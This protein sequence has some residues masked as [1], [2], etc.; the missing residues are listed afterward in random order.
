[1]NAPEPAVL[2]QNESAIYLDLLVLRCVI[3]ESLRVQASPLIRGLPDAAYARLRRTCAPDAPASNG[4]PTSLPFDEFDELFEL[5]CEHA[6]PSGELTTWLAAAIATAA[7]RDQH[8]WQDM[9]LPSRRELS[10]ILNARFPRL[11]ARNDR[12]MKWKKFFYRQLCE[13]AGVPICKSPNCADC[14][15]YMVCFG[16]ETDSC[17]A[18]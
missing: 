14:S 1:M 18:H 8:L 7:Q 13:R 9:G 16:P 4:V 12:D 6:E 17:D 2:C 10:A 11:A 5:L 15:D 3:A